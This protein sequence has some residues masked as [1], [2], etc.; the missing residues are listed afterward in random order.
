MNI[1]ESSFSQWQAPACLSLLLLFK[2]HWINGAKPLL[3]WCLWNTTGTHVGGKLS[4]YFQRYLD[5][6]F[7]KIII[8]MNKQMLFLCILMISTE[9][10]MFTGDIVLDLHNRLAF[11]SCAEL[12]EGSPFLLYSVAIWVKKNISRSVHGS[13]L[14]TVCYLERQK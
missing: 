5:R 3:R 10:P 9:G 2:T 4:W 8:C 1:W 12:N 14:T 11:Q 13:M 6:S 7:E